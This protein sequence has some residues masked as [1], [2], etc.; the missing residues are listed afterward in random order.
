MKVDAI[1]AGAFLRGG[2]SGNLIREVLY[3]GPPHDVVIGPANVAYDDAFGGGICSIST[4]AAWAKAVIP[5]PDSWCRASPIVA[6]LKEYRL[7]PEQD[8]KT[9]EIPFSKEVSDFANKLVTWGFRN[10]ELE[11]IHA[12]KYVPPGSKVV[13]PNGMTYDWEDVS[14]ISDDEM[15]SLMIGAMDKIYTMLTFPDL[16]M[17]YLSTKWDD[18]KLDRK[19]MLVLEA[20]GYFGEAKRQAA[21]EKL[22]L[23][24]ERILASE[25]RQIREE[26]IGEN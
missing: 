11:G 10:T 13:T 4:M 16:P 24:F 6:K 17:P 2:K 18:A 14:R 23:E 9:F 8:G 5:K 25:P 3:V 15:R 21:K 22:N 12:G 19:T 26:G 1:K 20:E 7:L